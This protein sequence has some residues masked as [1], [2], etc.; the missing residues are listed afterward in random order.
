M[1]SFTPTAKTLEEIKDALK[2]NGVKAFKIERAPKIFH[3][4]YLK[5]EDCYGNFIGTA[6]EET[7]HII[8]KAIF[9]KKKLKELSG[10]EFRIEALYGVPLEQ[11]MLT[12][13]E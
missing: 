5:F 1:L 12:F 11:C 4:W 9:G 2:A 3:N 7:A 10:H 6:T 8:L 13:R